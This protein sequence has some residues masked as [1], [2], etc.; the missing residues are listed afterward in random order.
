MRNKYIGLLFILGLSVLS[1]ACGGNANNATVPNTN[2]NANAANG[3]ANSPLETQKKTPE[4]VTNDAPTLT[5]VIKAY[6]AAMIKGDEAALRKIYSSDT[7]AD[8]EKQMKEDKVKTLVKFLEDDKMSGTPCEAT[9]EK[10]DGDSATA[11]MITDKYPKPGLKVKF[12]KQNGEWKLTNVAPD[13]DA[14]KNAA[15]NS[16]TAK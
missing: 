10:I 14:V 16:N 5:P 12:V 11:F 3:N 7:I 8:F 1:A 9:N 15:A 6:C 13:F 4:A 2:N